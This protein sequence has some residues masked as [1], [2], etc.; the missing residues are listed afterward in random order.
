MK[1]LW[2]AMVVAAGIGL[3]GSVSAANA[4]PANAGV[5]G[6]TAQLGVQLQQVQFFW[7]GRHWRHRRLVCYRHHFRHSRVAR[8]CH[9][10][11]W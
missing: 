4:A 5:I 3:I 2:Y 6:D 7:H 8:R 9:W 11:Y 10:R 1:K